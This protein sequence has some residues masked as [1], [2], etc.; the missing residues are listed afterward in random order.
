MTKRLDADDPCPARDGYA[1]PAEWAPHARTWMCWPCRTEAWGGPD[2][3]LRAKQAYARVARAISSF[4]PVVIAARP[5]DT[6]EAKLATSG[7][8][9]VVE[10]PLDDSWAR[11][12]GPTFLTAPNGQRAAVQWRFNAWGNKYQPWDQDAQFATR[13]AQHSGVTLYDAPLIC[14]GGA[15][16]SDGEGTLLTT[17][18]T[19]LNPNRNPHLDRQQVEERLALFTGARRVIWLGEGF[20]DDETD[21]HIDNIACFA[22]PGRVIVGVPSSRSHPDFEPVMD[23]IRRFKTARDAQ[24]R[25]L[26]VVELEQ[27]KSIAADWRGRPLQASYVNFYIANG[28]LVMPGFDDPND[29]KAR[30]VLADCFGERDILQIQALDIVMGG[31]GIHCITQQEPE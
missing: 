17:E 7:K 6:A 24:G 14:E 4:E 26:E 20:S 31:G 19:L 5:H 15:I 23:A 30:S 1:M 12:I 13:A 2:G 28:G 11:D 8:V 18:Q 10:V 9:E 25:A 3:L 27:P 29:E 22:S 16:H 21:G